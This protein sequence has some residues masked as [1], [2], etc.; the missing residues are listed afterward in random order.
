MPCLEQV[1][2]QGGAVGVAQKL[3]DLF[4]GIAGVQKAERP[5]GKHCAERGIVDIGGQR[6]GGFVGQQ[7]AV[8]NGQ[9][10][11]A[12]RVALLVHGGDNGGTLPFGGL[13]N[14]ARPAGQ[15]NVRRGGNF[16]RLPVRQQQGFHGQRFQHGTRP[17]GVVGMGM[18]QH[19]IAQRCN[20]QLFQIRQQGVGGIVGAGV[21]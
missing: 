12:Q 19:K 4:F 9:A 3:L 13:Q 17:A 15:V 5:G 11:A 8:Q 16:L 18:G 1:R 2:P 10:A 21:Q 20:V 6:R 14:A 7:P